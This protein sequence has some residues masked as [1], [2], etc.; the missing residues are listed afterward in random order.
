MKLQMVQA[1]PELLTRLPAAME[2]AI[3]N[4]Q[5]T[6]VVLSAS[7]DAFEKT[8]TPPERSVSGESK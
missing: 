8:I 7:L 3:S 1:I 4:R 2:G 6:L 5:E